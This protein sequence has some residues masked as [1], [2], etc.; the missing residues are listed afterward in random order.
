LRE[1]SREYNANIGSGQPDNASGLQLVGNK[2]N[3]IATCLCP[4]SNVNFTDTIIR[5][6]VV[7]S[8]QELSRKYNANIE[9]GQ[10]DN[11]M[12]HLNLL[13]KFVNSG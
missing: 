12:T 5:K 10:P 9:S 7:T 3:N 8:Q 4:N 2:V 13:C 6:T 1:L 11:A